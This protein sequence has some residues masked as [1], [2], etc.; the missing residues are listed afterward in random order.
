MAFRALSDIIK[1]LF[2]TGENN[3]VVKIFNKVEAKELSNDKF[4]K[5]VE[6]ALRRY[7]KVMFEDKE[8]R[9]H[10]ITQL[11]PAFG[12]K[13][14]LKMDPLKPISIAISREE[15]V[16]NVGWASSDDLSKCPGIVFP[17]DLFRQFLAENLD[18]LKLITVDKIAI[19][20]FEEL[21][22]I[23]MRALLSFTSAFYLRK[24]FRERVKAE[25]K[26]CTEQVMKE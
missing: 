19:E 15:N 16:F 1:E 7:K 3:T 21:N 14:I 17:F 13:V 11:E 25:F 10:L 23:I 4:L 6:T 18:V 20:K 12:H 24:D 2:P 22:D 5:I 9:F 8:L 26:S